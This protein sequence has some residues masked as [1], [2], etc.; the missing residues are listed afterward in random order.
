MKQMRRAEDVFRYSQFADRSSI[1]SHL[2]AY[3]LIL[4][5]QKNLLDQTAHQLLLVFLTEKAIFPIS[6]QLL[7]H[8]LHLCEGRMERA[9]RARARFIFF[10]SRLYYPQSLFPVRLQCLRHQPVRGVHHL[11][12]SAGQISLIL[13]ALHFFFPSA[14][15]FGYLFLQQLIKGQASFQRSFIQHAQEQFDHQSVHSLR[16]CS[17]TDRSIVMLMSRV[18]SVISRALMITNTHLVA[19]MLTVDDSLQQCLAASGCSLITRI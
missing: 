18:A 8:F 19:A 9:A 13:Q 12:S 3:E 16:A 7:D 15:L 1:P 6:P 10:A 5:L 2:R 17:I 4:F 11:I 14:L